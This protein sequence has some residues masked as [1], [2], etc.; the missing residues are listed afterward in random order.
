MTDD[1]YEQPRLCP[2]AEVALSEAGLDYATPE[3]RA[4]MIAYVERVKTRAAWE[5]IEACASM[6]GAHELIGLACVRLSTGEPMPADWGL[7]EPRLRE[8]IQA[9][10]LA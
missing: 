10:I 2:I 8:S 7:L 1:Q 4:L 9:A 5:I 3:D 6:Y